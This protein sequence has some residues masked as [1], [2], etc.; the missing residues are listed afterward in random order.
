MKGPDYWEDGIPPKSDF[1]IVSLPDHQRIWR[2]E[3]TRSVTLDLGR[4]KYKY[5]ITKNTSA[6]TGWRYD[7]DEFLV[8]LTEAQWE[9]LRHEEPSMSQARH[10]AGGIAWTCGVI[11]CKGFEAT[12]KIEI[13]LHEA[14]H[15]GIDLLKDIERAAEAA[16][17]NKA[18]RRKH[19]RDKE[20]AADAAVAEQEKAFAGR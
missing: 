20:V 14:K 17:K 8:D 3:A 18:A 9:R 12:T 11:G 16:A 13:V 15:Q 6:K 5:V 4:G 2:G 1:Q 7:S 10:V 19:K